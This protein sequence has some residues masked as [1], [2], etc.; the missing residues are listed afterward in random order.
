MAASARWCGRYF[1][2]TLGPLLALCAEPAGAEKIAVELTPAGSPLQILN[3]SS[4]RGWE[5]EVT[6]TVPLQVN[7]LGWWDEGADGLFSSIQVGIWNDDGSSLL[8]ST[9]IPGGATGELLGP[10]QGGGRFRY[11]PITPLELD[12]AER[13]VIAGLTAGD[14]HINDGDGTIT[15]ATELSFVEGQYLVSPSGFEFPGNTLGPTPGDLKY[16]GPNFTFIVV[17]EPYAVTLIVIGALG[18]LRNRKGVEGAQ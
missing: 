3:D 2:L 10:D 1:V 18:L 13:Y 12:P 5:F 16:F 17:P 15:T 14:T 7:R 4:M 8:V 6:S 11:V 9:V